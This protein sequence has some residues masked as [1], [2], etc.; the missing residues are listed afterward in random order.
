MTRIIWEKIKETLIFPYLKVGVLI[1]IFNYSQLANSHEWLAAR[2]TY[3]AIAKL[4]IVR[5]LYA[6]ADVGFLCT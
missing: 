2:F 1:T 5:R 6:V 3:W 4:E